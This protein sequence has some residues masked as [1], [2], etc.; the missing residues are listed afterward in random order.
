MTGAP[1]WT[2]TDGGLILAVRVTPRASRTEIAGIAPLP[3]GRQ[4]LAIR[5]A[6]PPVE[7]AANSELI[8]FLVKALGLR[9]SAMTLVSG[10]TSRLKLLRVEGDPAAMIERLTAGL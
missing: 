6:A 3:D 10:E 9:K 5:L 1:P 7:G 4:A 8:A 2:E